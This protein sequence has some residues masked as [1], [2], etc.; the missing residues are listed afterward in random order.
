MV[1][2]VSLS[3]SARSNLLTLKNTADLLGQTQERLATGKKVNSSLDNAAAYFASEGFL[4]SANDLGSLKDSMGT[5]IQTIQSASDAIDSISNVIEQMKGLTNSALQ[6]TDTTTL[7][8]LAGQYNDLRTQLDGLV[9]DSIFNG[10]NLLNS[11]ATTL[12][13]YFNAA[14]TTSLEISAV[15]V[16]SAGLGVVVAANDW[17]ATS[18]VLGAQSLLQTALA[19]LRTEA[20][21]FG[22][23]NTILST[24]QDFTTNLVNTLQEAS[25]NLVL[26]DTNEEG[27]NLQALQAQSQL[28]IVALGISGEQAQA[29]LRLF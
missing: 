15:N 27:A 19:T 17:A 25:D 4:N 22:N 12:N 21:T 14:N 13:V 8:S 28:G 11:T 1:S 10:T 26:A 20:S 2:D 6:T 24:R 5:A 3:A 9:T 7:A 23:N 16:T 18:D 29:I